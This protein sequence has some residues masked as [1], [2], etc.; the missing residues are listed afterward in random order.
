MKIASKYMRKF[1][2]LIVGI[3]TS[4]F[5]FGQVSQVKSKIEKIIADKEL[6]LGFALY[7]F[8]TGD[9]LSINGVKRFPMQSVF[10]FPIALA[11]LHEV[12]NDKFELSQ[13]IHI[14]K[15]DLRP[16]LWSPIEK[17]YPGGE[18]QLPLSEILKQTVSLSDNVGCD[19]LLKLLD[20]PSF[21]NK[22]IHSKGITDICIQN[23]EQEIQSSWNVQ[24]DNW[25][26]PNAMI[27]LLKQFEAKELLLPDSHDFLWN[28]M[29]ETTTGFLKNKLPK[30]AVIVHKTG[31]SGYNKEGISAAT[32]DVGIMLLPN[33]NRI[34][35]VIFI[36]D[37]KE[38]EK[39]NADVIA[40][41]ATVLYAL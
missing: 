9:T 15:E 38:P 34:A 28:I 36:T 25:V 8:S 21:V 35:F 22:Y 41:I 31:H 29:A 26:T 6:V 17:K 2:I 5:A 24:F 39:V 1:I 37:S 19:L 10:K 16:G 11:M 20:G 7:D 23:N 32:N 40:D 18:I 30:N 33:G 3:A 4:C 27:Q 14:G 13:K 12:D